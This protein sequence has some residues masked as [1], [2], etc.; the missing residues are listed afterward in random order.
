MSIMTVKQMLLGWG[1]WECLTL[2]LFPFE[3]V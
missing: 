3:K 1:G 2:G